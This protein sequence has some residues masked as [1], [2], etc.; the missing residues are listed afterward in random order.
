MMGASEN[1]LIAA[2]TNIKFPQVFPPPAHRL[3]FLKTRFSFFTLELKDLC[4]LLAMPKL[5]FN[6]GLAYNSF[7]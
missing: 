6:F 3:K 7:S 1:I 4:K 2:A 5:K